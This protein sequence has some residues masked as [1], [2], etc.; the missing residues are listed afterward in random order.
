MRGRI[1][2]EFLLCLFDA[3]VDVAHQSR[4]V[5]RPVVERRACGADDTLRVAAQQRCAYAPVCQWILQEVRLIHNDST[6][7]SLAPR[8]G[9]G[10]GA[11][12]FLFEETGHGIRLALARFPKGVFGLAV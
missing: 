1:L 3:R 5:L 7:R 4:H 8:G 6:P 9:G 12:E 11:E 10:G 2:P